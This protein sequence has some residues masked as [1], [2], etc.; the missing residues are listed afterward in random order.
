MVGVGA[1]REVVVRLA[2]ASRREA[3]GIML[4]LFADCWWLFISG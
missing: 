4:S 1:E 2:R 3:V